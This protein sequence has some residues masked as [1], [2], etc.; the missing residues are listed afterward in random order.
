[1]PLP[2]PTAIVSPRLTIR[3]VAAADLPDLLFVNSDDAV[4]RHLP[5][6][7]WQTPSDAD[8][9]FERMRALGAAGTALQFVICNTASGQGSAVA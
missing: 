6:A 2:S 8:A 9:W 5:Y 4:A 3:L 1:M 7:T